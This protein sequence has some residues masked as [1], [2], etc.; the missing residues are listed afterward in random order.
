MDEATS[1]L[2]LQTEIAINEVIRKNF[3][4]HTIL[5]IGHRLNTI[6][7]A[8]KIMVMD[9]GRI[10]EFDTPR[11]LLQN[12]DGFF[13][14]MVLR[15]GEEAARK[16]REKVFAN[17]TLDHQPSRSILAPTHE[18]ISNLADDA[19]LLIGQSSEVAHSSTTSLNGHPSRST[20][21]RQDTTATPPDSSHT[22]A[23]LVSRVIV[24]E[25][26]ES[27]TSAVPESLMVFNPPTE[28]ELAMH[29][30]TNAGEAITVNVSST[31]LHS[32]D[33]ARRRRDD[34]DDDDDDDDSSTSDD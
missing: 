19:A 16:L 12:R 32:R 9:Q 22:A 2:D 7:D 23:T 31:L 29:S 27:T 5:Q 11:R 4:D 25:T 30:S 26:H 6:I 13:Y 33:D 3:A 15:S 24:Q 28:Q 18:S 34:D 1:I 14:S 17:S 10:V 21:P 8:D 20:T